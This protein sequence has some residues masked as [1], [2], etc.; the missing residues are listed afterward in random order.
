MGIKNYSYNSS[1][2]TTGE[3]R[4]PNY[5]MGKRRKDM[6]LHAGKSKAVIGENIGEM[7]KAGHPK[8]Q[9][10]AASLNKARESGAKIPMKHSKTHEHHRHKEHR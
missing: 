7:E 9:A 5:M 1:G 3:Q 8:A 2:I 4:A 6:P 10:I